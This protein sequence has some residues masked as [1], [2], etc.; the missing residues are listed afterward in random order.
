MPSPAA[1]QY[2]IVGG[3]Q[4]GGWAAKTLRESGFEGRIVL[5][6]DEPHPP[7]ER[8]PLSKGVLTALKEPESCYLWSRD[9][10]RVLGIDFEESVTCESIDRQGRRVALSDG[11]RIG[12]DRLLL[13]TGSRARRLQCP[14]AQLSGVQYLRTI[15]DSVDLGRRMLADQRL[16]VIGGGWIGLEVAASVSSKGVPVTI[17]E[18]SDRLCGRSLPLSLSRYFLDL[19]GSHGVEV[20]LN[21]K[22]RSLEGADRVERAVFQ[23]GT[24]LAVSSVVV[25]I[26][27]E[28]NTDL[29]AACGLQVGNGIVVDEHGRTSDPDVFAAGDVANQPFGGARLRFESWKNA[30]D[31]GISV[32]KAMLDL[33]MPKKDSPWFWS[34]QYDVNFQMVGVVPEGSAVYQKGSAATGSFAQYFVSE[35]R[36]EAVAAINSPK[37]VRDGKRAIASGQP[38]DTTGLLALAPGS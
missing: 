9:R 15:Q 7:Y 10:L 22:L 14:G 29:A 36:L 5:I 34:D 13:A 6:T 12:Y 32:A 31:N 8:P 33:D 30:Q 24:S 16:L 27:A 26:G 19:H 2:V 18:A 23:D 37:D 17:V 20:R 35:N 21:A 1:L 25:G 38:F 3:G 11:R 28:P 4:A